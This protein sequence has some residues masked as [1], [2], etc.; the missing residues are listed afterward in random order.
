MTRVVERV[1]F[2]TDNNPFNKRYSSP[3]TSKNKS[4]PEVSFSS[5]LKSEQSKLRKGG[6]R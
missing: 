1:I 6:A 2:P 4:K 5:V 3:R